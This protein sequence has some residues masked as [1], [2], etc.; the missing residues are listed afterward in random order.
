M[1]ADHGDRRTSD[2]GRTPKSPCTK[3]LPPDPADSSWSGLALIGQEAS[4]G[5]REKVL[6]WIQDQAPL[7]LQRNQYQTGLAS[8][9]FGLVSAAEM[10]NRQ[11]T[12]RDAELPGPA[13]GIMSRPAVIERESW[14]D[15]QS[16]ERERMRDE[17]EKESDRTSGKSPL[18]PTREM[19]GAKQKAFLDEQILIHSPISSKNDKSKRSGRIDTPKRKDK[20]KHRTQANKD[21]DKARTASD[22][23]ERA[24]GESMKPRTAPH[25][26]VKESKMDGPNDEVLSQAQVV[27]TATQSG[28]A[29]IPPPVSF[30]PSLPYQELMNASQQPLQFPANSNMPKLGF[31]W[32]QQ[33]RQGQE[34]LPRRS[35]SF[36][37]LAWPPAS[38]EPPAG[39]MH[40]SANPSSIG[41]G[42]Q[43]Q[44]SCR[45]PPL[46]CSPGT[47][48]LETS[49]PFPLQGLPATELIENCTVPAY[50]FSE[51]IPAA[52][53]QSP[54]PPLSLP[55]G[56]GL[57]D[58]QPLLGNSFKESVSRGSPRVSGDADPASQ[59]AISG[60][61]TL[62]TLRARM[63]RN[64]DE[65]R[66][67]LEQEKQAREISEQRL[68]ALKNLIGANKDKQPEVE[69]LPNDAANQ[70]MDAKVKQAQ[71]SRR[72]TNQ[73]DKVYD[74]TR[75]TSTTG[76]SFGHFGRPFSYQI[77]PVEHLLQS[78]P[79]AFDGFPVDPAR[80]VLMQRTVKA[81][82]AFGIPVSA[83]GDFGLGFERLSPFSNSVLREDLFPDNASVKRSAYVETVSDEDDPKFANPCDKVKEYEH[84]KGIGKQGVN[85][86]SSRREEPDSCRGESS[87]LSASVASLQGSSILYEPFRERMLYDPPSPRRRAKNIDRNSQAL[88]TASLIDNL[89]RGSHYHDETL[90]QLLLAARDPGLGDAAKWSLQRAARERLMQLLSRNNHSGASDVIEPTVERKNKAL[91]KS[92]G[93]VE[94]LAVQDTAPAWSQPLF[95]MLAETQ[96]RLKDLDARMPPLSSRE[97]TDTLAADDEI[98]EAQARAALHNLL[99]P[100]LPMEV[101]FGVDQHGNPHTSHH[102]S[103]NRSPSNTRTPGEDPQGIRATEKRLS[104]EMPEWG[105]SVE[106]PDG[107]SSIPPPSCL[108]KMLAKIAGGLPTIHIQPPTTTESHSQGAQHIPG[109]MATGKH[110]HDD[111]ALYDV[112][113][114][115]SVTERAATTA[116]IPPPDE[117]LS[118]SPLH[119]KQ[120]ENMRHII[121][122]DSAPKTK[123]HQKSR[124]NCI[125]PTGGRVRSDNL[126]NDHLE[127]VDLKHHGCAVKLLNP[128]NHSQESSPPT[129]FGPAV[130][131]RQIELSMRNGSMSR[132]KYSRSSGIRLAFRNPQELLSLSQNTE[133]IFDLPTGRLVTMSFSHEKKSLI[134]GHSGVNE[135]W[136]CI[137]QAWPQHGIP[138]PDH[139]AQQTRRIL[140]AQSA[141]NDNSLAAMNAARNLLL[142]WQPER[143]MDMHRLR[144]LVWQEARQ[145]VAH[146]EG[147]GQTPCGI[148]RL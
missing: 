92:P 88:T 61:E 11:L 98:A 103:S 43:Q 38:S 138:H 124:R 28:A 125:G 89:V 10:F 80:I 126:L 147:E 67:A 60:V 22:H 54:L 128:A 83:L 3:P 2:A 104:V 141:K 144:D 48:P 40:S 99:F 90:C 1:S 127:K 70:G 134:D 86:T 66:L 76:P 29:D 122:P 123:L 16:V 63:K 62:D 73:T 110:K 33:A 142:G 20:K 81:Q 13:H 109:Q 97:N 84:C 24:H 21:S 12:E 118:Q 146:E 115:V 107:E 143:P 121:Q 44:S 106:I 31:P 72:T 148:A 69:V 17:Y 14:M 46:E 140:T 15:A 23:G 95:E 57:S 100:N 87:A 133:T 5:A 77:D 75:P 93:N 79:T 9:G 119:D 56:L 32:G 78:M 53:W 36:Q 114:A 8:L 49:L 130:V 65:S 85:E 27:P 129:M 68:A 145:A 55:Y 94:P 39:Q 108:S 7:P 102:L 34:T 47:V 91:P 139:L 45:T 50:D 59:V 26:E 58:T 52:S 116:P 113:E 37:G 131:L 25:R 111:I 19:N 82:P 112:T 30:V 132:N 135:G 105:S 4:P 71:H 18:Q 101:P 42:E 41:I 136:H 6:P 96:M 35:E 137:R 64:A 74:D 117:T 51:G 120:A